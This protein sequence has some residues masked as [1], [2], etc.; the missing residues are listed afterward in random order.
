MDIRQYREN[1]LQTFVEI[2]LAS[3]D[4]FLKVKETLT[5]VGVGIERAGYKRLVP[6]CYILHKRGSLYIVH[7]KELFLLDGKLQQ[8]Q[9]TDEDRRRRNTIAFLLCEWGL[10][11]LVSPPSLIEERLPMTLVKVIPFARKHEWE[12][13]MKY[14]IGKSNVVK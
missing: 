12:I 11:S 8:T 1:L 7:F 9:F 3:P 13:V 10:A 2:R 14:N 4:D 5:R 6:S